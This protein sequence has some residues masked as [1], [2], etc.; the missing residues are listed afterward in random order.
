MRITKH[1]AR[2]ALPTLAAAAL[3]GALATPSHAATPTAYV[4]SVNDLYYEGS[5]FANK[6]KLVSLSAGRIVTLEDTTGTGIEPGTG[7][8][9][10]GSSNKVVCEVST[11]IKVI[12]LMT[13]GG[14]DEVRVD[15]SLTTR[16]EGGAGRDTYFGASTSTGTN[17]TFNGGDEVDTAD[18][19]LSTSGVLV[20]MDDQAD[21]GRLNKDHDNIDTTVENLLGSDFDDSLRG[22]S[23]KNWIVGREGADALRGGNNDD[24]IWATEAAGADGSKADKPDLSCGTGN[25][26]IRVDLTDPQV[27]G[28]CETVD[29]R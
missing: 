6:I 5:D 14:P 13:G 28:D 8:R 15:T 2:L 3:A 27:S 7:C 12:K 25:D 18:F 29:R 10:N 19:G 1:L 20:D 16:I 9:R 23:N 21:D 17:V 22:N 24:E 11:P 4:T 26:I